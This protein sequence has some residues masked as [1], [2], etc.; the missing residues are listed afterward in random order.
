MSYVDKL[1]DE[2]MKNYE[3]IYDWESYFNH[4][5]LTSGFLVSKNKI[6]NCEI[7][8]T[9][10]HAFAFDFENCFFKKVVFIKFASFE[11]VFKIKRCSF[12]ELLAFFEVSSR[13]DIALIDIKVNDISLYRSKCDVFRCFVKE[14]TIIS[15]QGG[16]Y[17]ELLIES[18]EPQ[19]VVSRIIIDCDYLKGHTKIDGSKMLIN[20]LEIKNRLKDAYLSIENCLV[21][22]ISI[23]KFRNEGAIRLSRI[24][25]KATSTKS[26]V[27]VIES[28]L[29]K[30]EFYV[31]DFKSFDLIN[32]ND[33]HLVDC[34]FVNIKWKHDIRSYT[35]DLVQS[36]ID[37][38]DKLEEKKLFT[39]VRMNIRKPQFIS[40]YYRR[41]RE[42]YRQL[43]YA[44]QKQG[45]IVHEHVYH[46]KEM[47]AHNNA[48]FWHQHPFTKLV[49][50]MSYW[51]SNFGQSMWRPIWALFT[52]H[53]F[54]YMLAIGVGGIKLNNYKIGWINDYIY[55][56]FYLISPLHKSDDIF[57]GWTIIIDILMRI[58]SSY[59]IYNIIRASRR[60][61]K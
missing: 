50:K 41:N 52:G 57:C 10:K 51:F 44:L 37:L 30:A 56:Y 1:T 23:A 39:H 22:K 15:V 7:N 4:K 24:K 18:T 48:L 58:W 45:S 40:D 14:A 8:I 28:Y 17:N 43:K 46:A 33:A 36:Q 31:V 16:E 38:I 49:I 61:I 27:Q 53:Y 47:R 11:K 34:S 42:V 54:M 19:I 3:V 60:F 9:G 13:T 12:D 5:S 55:N 2:E 59:M 26:E 35:S 29:G 6:F 25:G 20:Q 21:Q 32:I